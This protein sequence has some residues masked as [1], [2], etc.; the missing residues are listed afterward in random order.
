M[1]FD[2]YCYCN[3]VTDID[4]AGVLARTDEHTGC[5]GWQPRKMAAR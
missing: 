2:A 3:A 4:N 1:A 5:L